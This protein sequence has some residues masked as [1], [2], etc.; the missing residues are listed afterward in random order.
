L[1]SFVCGAASFTQRPE[2]P[3]QLIVISVPPNEPI[4]IDGTPRKRFTP[5]TFVV[6]PGN[7]SVSLENVPQCKGPQTVPV[8]SGSATSITCDASG[9]GK[10]T[11]GNKK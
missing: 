4:T 3:G 2:P 11:V 1:F 6:S 5:F 8:L 10:P 7:H 9:W